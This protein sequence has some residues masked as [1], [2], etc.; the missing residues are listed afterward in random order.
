[1]SHAV[2][3]LQQWDKFA[4]PFPLFFPKPQKE[5]GAVPAYPNYFKE[6]PEKM[7]KEDAHPGVKTGKVIHRE[8]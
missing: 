6:L 1:M 5:L 3:Y 2:Y 7:Q 4:N 8:I